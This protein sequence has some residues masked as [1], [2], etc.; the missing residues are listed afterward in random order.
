M[1]GAFFKKS[2][3]YYAALFALWA[4]FILVRYHG[5]RYEEAPVPSAGLEQSAPDPANTAVPLQAKIT[6]LRQGLAGV[7]TRAAKSALLQE[8][9]YAYANLYNATGNV[10][11]RD[12]A[13][14]SMR[15]ASASNPGS[16][17]LHYSLGK[18]Y[19]ALGNPAG[20]LEQYGLAMRCD[21]TYAPGFIEAAVC[22]YISFRKSADAMR[23]GN[24]ALRI[25]IH[26]PLCHLILGLIALDANDF[27]AGRLN[28]D[29]EIAADDAAMAAGTPA[30]DPG[31]I[32]FAAITAH[33]RLLQ[34]YCSKIP[35]RA[36]AGAHLD[37]YLKLETDPSK[38]AAAVE[39]MKERWGG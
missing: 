19:G 10:S 16:A 22:S 29:Q 11:F 6:E 23:F 25:D 4:V 24:R 12:S 1:T 34:L 15:D 13:V 36:K 2:F 14:A 9:G 31:S 17:P 26:A 32:R 5:H 21:S 18:F 37:E 3:S 38:K 33:F 27:E 28:L 7:A 30:L 20:A 35:D 8:L 39:M